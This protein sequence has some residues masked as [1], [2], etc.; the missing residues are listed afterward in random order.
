MENNVE[1]MKSNT[2][3]RHK[4]RY[5]QDCAYF[6]T[7]PENMNI[8]LCRFDPPKIMAVPVKTAQGTGNQISGQWPPVSKLSGCRQH[9]TVRE[10]ELSIMQVVTISNGS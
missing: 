2:F 3:D 5:C 4:R 6:G 10:H 9:R 8:G 7:N 1:S